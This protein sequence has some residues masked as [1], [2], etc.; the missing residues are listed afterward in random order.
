MA[1]LRSDSERQ[2]GKMNA[3]QMLAHCSAAIGMAEGKVNLAWKT[4]R[5]VGQ[6][7]TN[8]EWR[9]HAPKCNDG[10]ERAGDGRTGLHGGAE[11]AA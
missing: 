1:H 5:T 4:V 6:E 9:A 10:A 8:R 2:W 3:A 7:I 11:A